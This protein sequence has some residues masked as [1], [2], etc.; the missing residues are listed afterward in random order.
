MPLTRE[1]IVNFKAQCVPW[2]ALCSGYAVFLNEQRMLSCK[3]PGR[4]TRVEVAEG[5]VKVRN[6]EQY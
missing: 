3:E 5:E 6:R 2:F 4:L 1:Q